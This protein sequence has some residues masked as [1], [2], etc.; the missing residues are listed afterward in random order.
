MFERTKA[1][2][3]V[4]LAPYIPGAR[5]TQVRE[6][7][8]GAALRRVW[9]SLPLTEVMCKTKR[10]RG[11][12]RSFCLIIKMNNNNLWLLLAYTTT[13]CINFRTQFQKSIFICFIYKIEYC[14]TRA[15][16]DILRTSVIA[17]HECAAKPDSRD[18]QSHE[19]VNRTSESHTI[20]SETMCVNIS[21][22]HSRRKV[23][24]YVL[25]W[26]RNS[27]A[28]STGPRAGVKFTFMLLRRKILF[29][30]VLRDCN[31]LMW[32]WK[33]RVSVG[34]F[35]VVLKGTIADQE[36]RRSWLL[37]CT[38]LPEHKIQQSEK[39]YPVIYVYA[40]YT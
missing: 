1:A 25:T 7:R 13:S 37:F 9:A 21:F 16:H 38:I 30:S 3:V 8:C 34:E 24:L 17:A 36:S 39:L 14:A 15:S 12:F 23:V 33:N 27:R 4:A 2:R 40:F 5:P 26:S 18:A 10:C 28:S 6:C 32:T 19:W 29:T 31:A 20:F 22:R 11:S 35:N